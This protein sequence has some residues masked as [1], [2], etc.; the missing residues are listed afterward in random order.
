MRKQASFLRSAIPFQYLLSGK[1]QKVRVTNS[2]FTLIWGKDLFFGNDAG[3]ITAS[4]NARYFRSIEIKR[5]LSGNRCR[6]FD[7]LMY[8]PVE[9]VF[10]SSFTS[11]D[12]QAA[13]KA[14]DDQIDKLELTDDA[15]K[16]LLADLR[17]GLDMV[18]SGYN[19]FGKCHQTL[20]V[21]ADTPEQK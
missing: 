13:V 18:S 8:L 12:K 11:M 7:A 9:Y 6:H 14:L 20:I 17:V 1:W 2:P 19:S 3:Q 15:A 10:T 16:S 4:Q 21:F 5:L